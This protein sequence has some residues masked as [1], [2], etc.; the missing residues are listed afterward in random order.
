MPFYEYVCTE[1]GEQTE[2]LQRLSDPPES[3]CP[4]C[5]QQALI[6]QVSAAGFRLKG[7]GW[8][9]TDFKSGNKRNIEGDTA[10]APVAAVNNGDAKAETKSDAKPATDAAAP[11]TEPKGGPKNEPKREA[12]PA[13]KTE[14]SASA[15]AAPKA[16][17]NKTPA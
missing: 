4:S 9:E 11:K 2:V 13:A 3:E 16:T 15:P 6:K 1:C 12:K 10:A 17:D 5:H 8:Y 14:N 7:G